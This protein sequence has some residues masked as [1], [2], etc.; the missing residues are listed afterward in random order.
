MVQLKLTFDI[1]F[2]EGEDGDRAREVL[3]R[4]IA[5]DPGPALHGRP[6]GRA[7]R[8]GRVRRGRGRPAPV[9]GPAPTRP[10]STPPVRRMTASPGWRCRGRT[11]AGSWSPAPAAASAWRPPGSLAALGADVVLAVRNPDK[12]EAAAGAAAGRRRGPPAR[13][14]RP[15]VGARVR[16][17]VGAVDVLVNNAGVMAL[18]FGTVA[19]RLRDP[20]RHQPPRPLRAG[21]PAAA[22]ADRP[23]RRR[24]L[25]LAPARRARRRR[26]GLGA[27]RLPAVRGVRPVQARQP[28]VPG[29]APAP[30][31]RGR[32]DAAR[33]PARTPA[34]ADRHHQLDRQ[35]RSRGSSEPRQHAGR[36]A[37]VAGRADHGVRRHDGPARQHLRRSVP[38]GGD[39]RLADR[40]G[41]SREPATPT[42]PRR[43]GPRRS[44]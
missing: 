16:R 11:G 1:T 19:R 44:S 14:R 2:P 29:R 27:A 22:A 38:A 13:R 9:L 39:A 23:G 12:G 34:T 6:H 3:P 40:V 4:T 36:D 42:W 10:A 20:A 28:A 7:R 26:P 25:G 41:R 31:D 17:R 37:G 8:A 32:L 30:A 35:P 43:C 15:V 5:A 18:P 33:R 24:R 21:Q